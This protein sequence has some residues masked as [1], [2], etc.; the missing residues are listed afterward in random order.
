M[1]RLNSL[2][3][4]CLQPLQKAYTKM[5]TCG[6]DACEFNFEENNLGNL[7]QEVKADPAI[8]HFLVETAF[9][10]FVS[11]RATD[12]TEPFPSFL[13]KDRELRPKDG[14]LAYIKEA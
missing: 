6:S 12:L 10:A 13:L 5:R 1:R 4:V 11:S 3:F 2:C 9:M 14:N 8:A 7:F